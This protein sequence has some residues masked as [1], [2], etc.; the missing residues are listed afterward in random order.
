MNKNQK[1]TFARLNSKFQ[2]PNSTSGSSTLELLIAFAILTLSLTAGILIIFGNQSVAVDTETNGE[3]LSRAVG[4]IEKARADSR[5]SFTSVISQN[6]TESVGPISYNKSLN[7]ID[8][9]SFTKQAIGIVT[10][11]EGGRNQSINISTIFTD[12][13]GALGGDT[14]NP[15]LSGDWTRPQDWKGGYGYGD[16]PSPNGTSGLDS[17]NKKVYLTSDVSNKDDFYIFD[18]SNPRPAGLNLPLL[19]SLKSTYG[20]TD[21]R[22]AGKYAYV[23]VHSQTYQLFVIDISV[24]S[25]PVIIKKLRVTSAGDTAYGNTIY[26]SKQKVYLGLT[27][28][29]GKELHIIDVSTPTA[30]I[31]I[32]PGFE[33]NTSIN[34]ILVKD[35]IAYLTTALNNQAW[36]VDVS[37]ASNPVQSNPL[38]QTFVDP[39]GTQDWSG[40]S[41]AFGDNKVY[42]GRI[43][44]IGSNRP[45]LYI[46]SA[47]DLSLAPL[48]TLTQTKQDGVTRLVVRSNLLFM[49]N[50][51]ANDGFQIWDIT[52]PA[53]LSR[54][55]TTPANIQQ[56]STAGMDCEGNLVYVGQRSGH[57]LQIIGPYD[58]ATFDYAFSIPADV[59]VTRAGVSKTTSFTSTITGG[60]TQLVNLTNSALPSGA[61]L[62]YSATSCSPTCFTTLTLSAS[63]I[64]TLGTTLVTINGDLPAKS[65]SFNLT[66]NA[67][68]FAYTLPNNL[69]NIVLN[70]GGPSVPI[71][72]TVTMAAGAVPQLVTM[73]APNPAAIPADII[74]T[75]SAVQSC[76]PSAVS[77][78]TCSVTF[79][80]KA[81]ATASRPKNY[82]NQQISGLPNAILTNKFKITVN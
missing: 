63:D 72:V 27:K 9:D 61:T 65:T 50:A 4:L 58:P 25:T 33:T 23:S 30:P 15:N 21:V 24:P 62:N 28:S 82:N 40:Q 55:D 76:T 5:Q 3:A 29:N 57:A 46:L 22:V 77:P 41:I 26:Y 19:G 70:H 1:I 18:V 74:I 59:T 39:S 44:D 34:Q 48:G 52:N 64:A 6:N 12:P 54:Y 42:L 79:N 31:D 37:N 47:N 51:A 14:C 80:Y 67:P 66:V 11:I 10:W 60:V 69:V 38:K 2:I 45:D 56:T 16:F 20:L 81:S 75:P 49:T 68:P 35:G 78:Y 43:F 71:T 32:S 36:I 17:L 53:S 7:I 13:N 8:L 73:S